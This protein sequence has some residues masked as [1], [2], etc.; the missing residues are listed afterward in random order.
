MSFQAIVGFIMVIALV[1]CLIRK[2]VLPPIAFNNLSESP[3]Q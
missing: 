1:I 3:S 2:V